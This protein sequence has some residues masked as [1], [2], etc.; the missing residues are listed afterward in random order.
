[1]VFGE[2]YV[3]TPGD[4][5]KAR[6]I[7]DEIARISRVVIHPKFRGIG[8]GAFLVK[9]TL[10]KVDAKV[11]EVLAVMARYNPFFEKAGMLRVD[12]RRDETGLDCKI[13]RFLEEHSFDFKLAK[14]KAY[15]REFFNQLN[16]DGR[17]ALLAY[18]VEFA[19]QPFVK[20]KTAS[21]DLISKVL[22]SDGVY[23]YWIK[24]SSNAA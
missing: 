9:E 14:S 4:L 20:M 13:K 22:S 23:L 7:N 6:L 12:Y 10:H 18:L 16:G 15:C 11:V 2:R 8:L 1:M 17:R 3:F 21:L 19:R 5:H 24:S